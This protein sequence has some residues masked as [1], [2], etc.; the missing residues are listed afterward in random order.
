[1]HTSYTMFNFKL[2]QIFSRLN[3][4]KHVV[5]GK[6]LYTCGDIEGHWG[7]DGELYLCDFA[8]VFPPGMKLSIFQLDCYALFY[9]CS[10]FN[11][12]VLFL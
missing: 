12:I 11:I 5:N 1:M 2:Q 9:F 10:Y 3:L 8:R 4:K 7:A 6:Y